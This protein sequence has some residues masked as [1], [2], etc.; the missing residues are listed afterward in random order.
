MHRA[1][2][3]VGPKKIAE[4]ANL[5]NIGFRIESPS[6]FLVWCKQTDQELDED[7]RVI[8]TFIVDEAG[9]L[10][11]ADRRSEHVVCA[12]G[13]PVLSASEMTLEIDQDEVEVVWTTNQSTGYCPEPE[14]WPMIGSALHRAGIAFHPGFDHEFDFRRCEKCSAINIVKDNVFECGVCRTALPSEWN[15]EPPP[16]R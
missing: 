10:R 14:S 2:R 7:G 8:A 4:R 3:Y 16:L 9:H 5:L 13:N 6:G 12:G 11:I 15:F 1:Y